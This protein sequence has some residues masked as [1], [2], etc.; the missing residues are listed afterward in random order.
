MPRGEFREIDHAADL[1]LD[2][3]GADPGAVLEA[4]QRGL[5]QLLF[6]ETPGLPVEE[7]RT[8]SLPADG[9]PELLK[10]WCERL[11]R[12][13]EEDAFVPL[14]SR[15]EEVSPAGLRA[16]VRGARAPRETLAAASE[17]KAVTWHQLALEPA[18]GGGWRGRVIF[19]V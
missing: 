9:Y 6:G 3:T 14:E 7:E 15:V 12:M 19:D 2:L 4:A 8:L 16:R 17:L 18:P 10:E 13:I 1:G 5:V 11:Y